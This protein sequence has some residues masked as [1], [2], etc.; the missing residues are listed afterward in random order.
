MSETKNLKLFKHDNVTT[1]TNPLDINK[2]LNPNWDKLDEAI[3]EDRENINKNTTSIETLE[4]DNT[5]IKES[6]STNAENIQKNIDSINSLQQ[7]TVESIEKLKAENEA[8][9]S[10]IPTRTSNR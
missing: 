5:N 3:G 8:L 9:K 2:A 10:Q 6:I 1:N 4:S 7:S